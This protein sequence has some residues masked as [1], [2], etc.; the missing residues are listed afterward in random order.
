[1]KRL[2]LDI[3]TNSVGWC[4]VEYSDEH[5]T[6]ERILDIGSRIF[7]DGRA[8]KSGESLAVGRRMARGMRRR[9]DRYLGR[10][11]AFLKTLTTYGLMPADSKKAKQIAELDPYPL[12]ARALDEE[13]EPYE[14]GRI[15]FHLNQRRGFKSNRKVERKEGEDGKIYSG[16]KKLDAAMEDAGARTLGEFLNARSTKRVRMGGENKD[17][18]FYPQRHHI[19][20]EFAAIWKAQ[21]TFHPELMTEAARKALH[22]I[23]FFQRPLKEQEVGVC[24]FLTDEKRLPKAHPLFQERRLYEE[25]NHL[26]VTTPGKAS[27][28]L[29]QDERDRLVRELREKKSMAF[30]SMAKKLKLNRGQSFNKASETRTKL[31][32]N[33]IYATMSNKKLFGNR[34]AHF[35]VERRWLIVDRL[36]NE[37]DPDR[38]RTFLIQECKLD[39]DHLAAV[40]NAANGLPEGHG[41]LGPSATRLIL[42]ELKAD[43]ITYDEAVR[44]VA[45]KDSRFKHHSDFRTGEILYE[46]PYYG[47]LLT[48]EIPPG[49]QDPDD[50]PEKRWAKS[51]I[52]LCISVC[53]KSR[54]W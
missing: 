9:R 40:E 32:G 54:S 23:L 15:L 10:R 42:N 18:D 8:P 4:L 21:A 2:G 50:P 47:E 35:D 24:T 19:E 17:Y 20:K 43:I 51:P 48:R 38:L 28:K 41:R 37:E 52:Q 36:L 30:S 5:K 29:T 34:W 16:A 7:S 33:E 45:E 53:G 25:V 31:I 49:T 26:E 3:G 13:L 12:R 39:A 6:G 1:M 27:R 14:I 46:L 44:R 22:R 11:S